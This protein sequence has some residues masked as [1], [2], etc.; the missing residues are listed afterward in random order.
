MNPALT[1]SLLEHVHGLRDDGM[2]VLF[3]EHDMDVVRDV[4]DW[5]VVMAQGAI[6]AEGPPDVVMRDPAVIDAYLGAH[7]DMDLED[8][9]EDGDGD[10]DG[11]DGAGRG[12]ARMTSREGGPGGRGAGPAV[13]HGHGRRLR[14]GAGR[15]R[16]GAAARRAGHRRRLPAGHQHPRGHRADVRRRRDRRR[17]RAERRRQVDAAEGAVRAHPGPLGLVCACAARTSPPGRRTSWSP[18]ASGSC[19]RPTTSSRASPSRT[20]SRWGRS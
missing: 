19:R 2:T 11:H 12:G 16:P 6:A 8:G 15:R 17:H 3:V 7:H 13:G 10:G 9:D 20:T 5:V 18:G 1:Q 14:E 4:S